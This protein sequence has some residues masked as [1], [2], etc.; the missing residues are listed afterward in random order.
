MAETRNKGDRSGQGGNAGEDN[1]Q[2]TPQGDNEGD[3]QPHQ[4]RG[5]SGGAKPHQQGGEASGGHPNPQPN[6]PSTSTTQDTIFIGVGPIG[7]QTRSPIA[8]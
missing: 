7:G 4:P 1:P 8:I 2:P 3:Q 5:G 6:P